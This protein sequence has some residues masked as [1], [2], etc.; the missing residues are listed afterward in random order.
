MYIKK[1]KKMLKFN[2]KIESKAKVSAKG[3]RQTTETLLL[4]NLME[5][6]WAEGSRCCDSRDRQGEGNTLNVDGKTWFQTNESVYVSFFMFVHIFQCS[7]L[8]SKHLAKQG[9][10]GSESLNQ[11]LIQAKKETPQRFLKERWAL[12]SAWVIC[13]GIELKSFLNHVWCM[14][15]FLL[16]ASSNQR[17]LEFLLHLEIEGFF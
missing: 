16:S 13:E 6:V 15:Q 4:A 1:G 2:W 8:L 12:L 17:L 3:K 10:K 9:S 7:R 11:H 5:T 14:E